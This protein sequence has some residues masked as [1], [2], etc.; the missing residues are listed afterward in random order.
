M[1][2]TEPAP[3]TAE[4]AAPGR[5]LGRRLRRSLL[6]PRL[7]R[8]HV[9]AALLCVALGFGVVAQ[10]RQ[11][12]GDALAGLRQDDLVRL[13]D[14]LTQ[15]N[16]AL[17]DE[18]EVLRSDLAELR[19]SS[20]SRQAAEEA[21]RA[22]AQVQGVLAGTVPVRG[23]GVLVTIADPGSDVRAQTLVTVLEELRNAGAEAIELSGQ[24]LTASSWI[25]DAT[26]DGVVVDG[27][28]I[29]PPY[30]WTAV[31]DPG[32]LYV[33]LEIP[34]GALAA[35]R[36]AGGVVRLEEADAVEILA[37]RDLDEPV[38]AVPQPVE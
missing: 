28:D 33:A 29:S 27:V 15:R 32:T 2:G 30:R 38:H 10:V 21:A 18:Q 16:A 9:V 37:V 19:S 1:T 12:Q 13:L 17:A 23:P 24:R 11:T 36:N 20:S 26:V 14:E 4:R 5:G 3:A 22:Q 31:G 8:T 35:V 34:G 6:V 25:A 7:R